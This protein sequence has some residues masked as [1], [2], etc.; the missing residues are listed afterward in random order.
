M[1]LALEIWAGPCG[2]HLISPGRGCVWVRFPHGG[3]RP[4]RGQMAPSFA[5][6]LRSPY[7]SLET[8]F[9]EH[10]ERHH[11]RRKV[12]LAVVLARACGGRH[13]EPVLRG[14]APASTPPTGPRRNDV[15]YD[16]T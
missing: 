3:V 8:V 1:T 7:R 10:E 13:A 4:G 15:V 6:L 5:W 12:L 9:D 2:R 14:A 11:E 16:G